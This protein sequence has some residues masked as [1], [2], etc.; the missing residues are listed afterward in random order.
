MWGSKYRWTVADLHVTF[1]RHVHFIM[2]NNELH[3][4]NKVFTLETIG[5]KIVGAHYLPTHNITLEVQI[6][7]NIR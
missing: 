6:T 3:T 7:N 2:V 1:C 5:D 4:N